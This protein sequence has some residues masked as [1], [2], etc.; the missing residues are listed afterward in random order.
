M[1]TAK[2][3]L[4]LQTAHRDLLWQKKRSSPYAVGILERLFHTPYV[5]VNDVTTHFHM[6][7]PTAAKVVGQLEAIGILKEVSGKQRDK[8]YLCVVYMNLLSEGA[9]L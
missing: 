1:E 8:R 6:T 7:Y 4:E 9:G 5:S 2:N 3:I